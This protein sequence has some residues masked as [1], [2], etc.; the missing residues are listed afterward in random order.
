[1]LSFLIIYIFFQYFASFLHVTSCLVALQQ[2]M[3]KIILIF[4]GNELKLKK[5]SKVIPLQARCGPEGG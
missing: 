4:H 2:Q 1:M 5:K 3:C